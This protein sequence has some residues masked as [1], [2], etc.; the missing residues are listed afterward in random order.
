MRLFL[1]LKRPLLNSSINETRLRSLKIT[2]LSEG[3]Q[4]WHLFTCSEAFDSRAVSIKNSNSVIIIVYNRWWKHSYLSES[5]WC[6]P[7]NQSLNYWHWA[8][9]LGGLDPADPNQLVKVVIPLTTQFIFMPIHCARPDPKSIPYSLG[10]IRGYASMVLSCVYR[11]GSPLR[12][13]LVN[14]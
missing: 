5:S 9:S 1:S 14:L 2:S 8:N 7:F 13:V 3:Q 10:P 6:L 4:S 12:P 11:L